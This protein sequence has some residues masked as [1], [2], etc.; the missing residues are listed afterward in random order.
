MKIKDKLNYAALIRAAKLY[1]NVLWLSE[2]DPESAWILLVSAIETAANCWKKSKYN[3]IALFMEQHHDLA[4]KIK[5]HCGD[6]VLKSVATIV[7]LTATKKFIEFIKHFNGKPRKDRTIPRV[8]K[9]NWN[10]FDSILKKIYDLRSLAL[11]TGQPFPPMMCETPYIN[12]DNKVRIIERPIGGLIFYGE[13][14]IQPSDQPLMLWK[15]EQ[16]VRK[17]LLK[18]MLELT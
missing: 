8:G 2:S 14:V 17:S 1:S 3:K 9:A 6:S 18:W 5:N 13:T 11:H 7:N 15:F 12:T 16:I 10:E 4:K